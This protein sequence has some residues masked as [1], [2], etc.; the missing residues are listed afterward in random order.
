M[1]VKESQKPRVHPGGTGGH[2]KAAALVTE[3][4]HVFISLLH[5]RLQ[6]INLHF[7]RGLHQGPGC[8]MSAQPINGGIPA[9][10]CQVMCDFM[11][12]KISIIKSAHAQSITSPARRRL[13]PCFHCT[14]CLQ[15]VLVA[16]EQLPEGTP[17]IRG[18]DFNICNDLDSLMASMLSTGLQASALGQA[19]AEVNRM[20]DWR[21]SDEALLPA[22]DPCPDPDQRAA[23]RCKIFLGYTSNLVS[24]G[25]REHVRFLVQHRLVDVVV[26]TAGGI[27]EDLIKCMGPTFLGDFHLKGA[28]LRRRGLNRVG[29]MLVPNSNYC[30]F[31]DWVMPIFDAMLEEQGQPPAGGEPDADPVL[32]TPSRMI[33]RLGAEINHPDSICYWA[34]RNGIPIFCPALT[35]GSLGDMLYFHSYKNPGLVLDIVQDIRLMN[36]QALKA[37]P[38]KTGVIILGGGVPKHHICNANLMRNGADFAVYLNTAQEFDG[39]D[40]GARPD[41]AVSWGKIKAEAK[42]VKVYGDASIL[43]PLLV[44]QT[45]AKRVS[46]GDKATAAAAAAE[47]VE[48]SEQGLVP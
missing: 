5:I 25:V 8:R 42:P 37:T 27:E 39:S 14:T 43:F 35:D 24:A 32:W 2:G 7:W 31:E 11:R 6:F 29:N 19:V 15:A 38:R 28:D 48:K 41:E 16:S 47:A 30:K 46:A 1:L 20:L 9:G 3:T 33:A 45:F 40:S 12:H 26:T 10:A 44:S 34:A 4:V 17:Q 18:H 21:L 22:D 36:D 13:T 23:T